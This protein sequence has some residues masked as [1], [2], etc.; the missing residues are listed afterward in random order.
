MDTTELLD[1]A[2]E[3][4]EAFGYEMQEGDEFALIFAYKKIEDEIKTFCNI[5]TVPEELERIIV[6]MTVGEFL[7]S[8]K[9]FAPDSLTGID[10]DNAVKQ[11]EL[12]DTNV[13]FA[14]GAGSQ[15]PEQRLDSFIDCLRH[16]PR[17]QFIAHRKL[18]W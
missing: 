2:K 10:L 9:T 1:M 5:K 12:G 6:D 7:L 4:V 16:P 8:K 18:R 14:V 3:R 11:I 15:T 17:G 13:S